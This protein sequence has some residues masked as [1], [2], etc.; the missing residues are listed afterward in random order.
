M[1]ILSL[2]QAWEDEEAKGW[3][4]GFASG[5]DLPGANGGHVLL[6]QLRHNV[7]QNHLSFFNTMGKTNTLEETV[8][9]RG[10]DWLWWLVEETPPLEG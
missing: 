6:H 7:H 9:I 1:P 10:D 8:F 4:N 2:L 3:E 5:D